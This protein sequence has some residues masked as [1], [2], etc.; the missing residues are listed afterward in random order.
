MINDISYVLAQLLWFLKELL[1][2]PIIM[3][4][5]YMIILVGVFY[6]FRRILRIWS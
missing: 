2:I 6:L 4:F 3:Q 5:C 1:D